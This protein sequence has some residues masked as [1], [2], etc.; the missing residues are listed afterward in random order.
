[1]EFPAYEEL[2]ERVLSRVP[3]TVDKREG[4]LIWTAVGPVCAELC[5]AYLELSAGLDL[6]FVDTSAGEYLDRLARQAGLSRKEA[7]CAV[8]RGEFT[9][10]DGTPMKVPAG[11]RFGCGSVFYKRGELEEEGVYRLICQ[12]PGAEGNL[13][14]GELLPVDYLENFGAAKITGLISLG[15]PAETDEELRVRVLEQAM[16]PAFGGNLADYR[17]KVMA[18]GGVGAVKVTPV[19]SGGGTVRLTLLNEAFQPA[20][21]ELTAAVKAAADPEPGM[22]KGF[23][24][25]GHK[26]EVKAAEARVIPVT[27]T[28]TLAEGASPEEGKEAAR[29]AVEQYFFSLRKSW[30]Q[31]ERL[32]VRVSQAVMAVLSAEGILDASVTLDG[33]VSNLELQAEEVPML[34]EVTWEIAEETA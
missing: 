1:M 24:P 20:D 23:A 14:S 27:G 18:L 34:G 7:S 3:G 4:S 5:Q 19:P 25:I 29:K 30:G 13:E 26:V 17:E 2:M 28:L 12:Q 33:K 22:G 16:D 15:A 9:A 6:A 21:G 10:A 32:V 8:C 11:M 31:E